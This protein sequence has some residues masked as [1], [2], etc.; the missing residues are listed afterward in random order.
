MTVGTELMWFAMNSASI[1][2]LAFRYSPGADI[3]YG[4]YTRSPDFKTH[5]RKNVN[6]VKHARKVSERLRL[7]SEYEVAR[8]SRPLAY[9]QSW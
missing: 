9:A 7:G 1:G 3:F 5:F 4:Q 6:Q 8:S 2:S